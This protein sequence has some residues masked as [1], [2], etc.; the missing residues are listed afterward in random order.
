MNYHSK[1]V[2]IPHNKRQLFLQLRDENKNLEY[3]GVWGFFGGAAFPGENAYH[4]AR[5]EISE[6]LMIYDFKNLVF[7]FT[8]F[9]KK[10]KTFF[11]IFKLN[12]SKNFYNVQEGIEGAYFTL[13]E[14]KKKKKF[15]KKRKKIFNIASNDVMQ[16]FY[17]KI[18]NN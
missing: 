2:I 17:R 5:R 9:Q 14:F 12:I 11:H 16:I 4:A 18:L 6:E 13:L 7:V 1:V 8:Y 3:P 15:S 10:T